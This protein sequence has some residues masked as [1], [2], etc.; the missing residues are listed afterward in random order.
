MQDW[1]HY[2]TAARE[3][4][5]SL[6]QLVR[7]LVGISLFT[8]VPSLCRRVRVP[9]I[10]GLILA[11]ILLGTSGLHLWPDQ[12]PVLD[13]FAEVGKLLVLFYA[14]MHVDLEQFKV[15]KLRA[16]VFGLAT[17][18]FPL[19]AGI[20]AAHKLGYG[21]NASVLIGSLI[22]SHTLLA[23]PI[24]QRL[25]L[26]G[27]ESIMVATAATIFTDVI[28]LLILA[29]CVSIHTTGFDPTALGM[30]VLQVVLYAFIVLVLIDKLARKLFA[31]ST[32]SL[33]AGLLHLLLIVTI[34]SLLAE[35]IHLEPIVGAFLS[36][37]AVSR[38]MKENQLVRR[39][40]ESLGTTLFLPA[41]FFAIG[42]KMDA[43]SALASIV[44]DWRVVL[45]LVGAL[46][47]GK[48]VAA[49]VAGLVARYPA[50]ECMNLWSLTLPQ[51]AST[52]AGTLVAYQALDAQGAR[53]IDE[54]ILNGVFLLVLLTTTLGPVLTEIFSKRI[55]ALSAA[56]PGGA[57]APPA[58]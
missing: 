50:I 36:G 1:D 11:G 43:R 52:I 17:L 15:A 58:A 6:P 27:R 10:V 39:H 3:W 35:Q 49:W 26:A 32:D 31:R 55:V 33:D 54:P 40:I 21:P 16:V 34:A 28:S 23:F 41:F 13:L 25:G 29:V 48:F 14:G 51:V 56:G 5:G 37:I 38:A 24:V 8:F 7:F 12:A 9:G 53:L 20:F 45:A 19:G 42:L 4:L 57:P 44:T 46:L 2:T 22:A 47:G 18:L 30:Q